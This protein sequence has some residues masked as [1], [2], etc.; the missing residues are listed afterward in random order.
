MRRCDS[1]KTERAALNEITRL[2]F[3]AW[4]RTRASSTRLSR[5][6]PDA[7]EDARRSRQ[8]VGLARPR[9]TVG[10]GYPQRSATVAKVQFRGTAHG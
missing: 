8:A 10:H 3:S 9:P 4:F 1:S 6:S 5:A 2:D 7:L